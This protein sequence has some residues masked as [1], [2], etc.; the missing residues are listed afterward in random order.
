MKIALAIMNYYEHGVTRRDFKQLAMELRR[1]GHSLTIYYRH[2]SSDIA[3]AE[4]LYKIKTH[5]FTTV[6]KLRSFARQVRK[7]LKHHPVDC[8]ITFSRLPGADIYYLGEHS[9]SDALHRRYGFWRFFIPSYLR[10][11]CLERQLFCK[12]NTQIFTLTQLQIDRLI[13]SFGASKERFVLLPPG[14]PPGF[15]RPEEAER[16]A[17]RQEVRER[18][19]IAEDELMAIQLG[20]GFHAKGVDRTLAALSTLPD[21]ELKKIKL[22]VGGSGSVARMDS[23]ARR[24]RI[25]D[26]VYFSSDREKETDLLAAAD[27]L[28]HPARNAAVDS[29]PLEALAFGVP[30]ICAGD[31]GF[32]DLICANGGMALPTPFSCR[33]LS[34]MIR[35]LVNTPEKLR[36]MK[37]AAMAFDDQTLHQR[38]P[39]AADLIEE[40]AK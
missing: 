35:L 38:I 15:V 14:I 36:E 23:L 18:I 6:G 34:R 8:F 7:R 16:A 13:E 39:R 40:F 12:S 28:I 17:K 26:R 4:H 29:V 21:G 25:R 19:G 11:R 20:P 5:A 24:L 2:S 1:R 31:Y 9:C 27:L 22:V 30:V 33:D 37:D 10:V 32:A 3:F